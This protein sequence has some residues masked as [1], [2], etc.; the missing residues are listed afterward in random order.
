LLGPK[1]SI[2]TDMPV[3]R[4]IEL[5]KEKDPPLAPTVAPLSNVIL[6]LQQ[7]TL[8]FKQPRNALLIV[9]L[10]GFLLSLCLKG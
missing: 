5:K 8:G 9:I 7:R 3:M 1:F 6:R 4:E 10:G 2:L